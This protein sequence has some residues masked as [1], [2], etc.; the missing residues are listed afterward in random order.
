MNFN[1]D[2]A[3]IVVD[4]DGAVFAID[5]DSDVVHGRITDLVV[6]GVD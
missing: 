6:C 4:G 5:V 2:T 3:S 1:R